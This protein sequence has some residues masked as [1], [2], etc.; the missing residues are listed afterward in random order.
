MLFTSSGMG[1]PNRNRH[2]FAKEPLAEFFSTHIVPHGSPLMVLSFT[3]QKKILEI[4]QLSIFVGNFPF[5]DTLAPSLWNTSE[6]KE[7]WNDGPLSSLY[8]TT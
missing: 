3:I 2:H 4:I 7:R 6:D 5:A 8:P 1:A